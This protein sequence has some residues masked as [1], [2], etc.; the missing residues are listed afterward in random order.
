MYIHKIDIQNFFGAS[1]NRITIVFEIKRHLLVGQE[2]EQPWEP[3]AEL[4]DCLFGWEENWRN[5]FRTGLTRIA[6]C[7]ELEIP[8]SV[9]NESKIWGPSN[10][11]DLRSQPFKS[12]W[13]LR[14]VSAWGEQCV[15]VVVGWWGVCP[16]TLSPTPPIAPKAKAEWIFFC[17]NS[18]QVNFLHP[19]FGRRELGSW[20]R[21]RQFLCHFKCY[22]DTQRENVFLCRFSTTG[23]YY[24][25]IFSSKI[26]SIE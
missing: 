15:G 25:I 24:Y 7:F 5:D 23:A 20:R 6:C 16:T 22:W 8:G 13:G 12:G 11:V 2:C 19:L 1:S 14:K 10:D 17:K 9:K 21:Q 18:L 26:L 4:A 3:R